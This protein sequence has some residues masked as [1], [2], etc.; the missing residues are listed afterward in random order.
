MGESRPHEA[1]SPQ[2]RAGIVLREQV[3]E[4]DAE[5]VRRI[6]QS[7]GFFS[8]AE[9]AVAVELVQERLS[10]GAASGYHFLL[11][12][13]DGRGVGYTCFGPIACTVGSFD[14]YWIAVHAAH[15]RRGL[16]RLLIARTESAVAASGGRRV[17]V[18]TSSRPL[19]E[20]TRAFYLRCG[21][22]PA[23]VL[24]DFYSPGDDKIIYVKALSSP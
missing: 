12:E 20:P 16:G 22:E 5:A 8:D 23:A 21:Y 19:Y 3:V 4:E 14:L 7:T 9:V 24:K 11:A 17:Y 10:R 18:E 6:V 15:R 1:L 2:A 13:Q